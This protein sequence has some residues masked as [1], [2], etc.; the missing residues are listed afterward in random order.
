MSQ[1][2]SNHLLAA[3]S[4]SDRQRLSLFLEPV[5]LSFGQVLYEPDQTVSDAYFP[6]TAVISQLSVMEAGRGVETASI[7]NEGIIGVPLVLGTDRIPVRL[8]VQI[9]G[10]AL[11]ISATDLRSELS[12]NRSLQFLLLRYIQTLMNQIAQH[13]TCTQLHSS[14]DRCCCLLLLTHDRIGEP[15]LSLTQDLLSRMVGVRRDRVVEMVATLERFGLIEHQRGRLTIVNRAGLEAT[16][17]DCYA[18]LRSQ[19][20]QPWG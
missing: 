12:A 9:P 10:I 20:D 5:P 6:T 16:A 8:T 7:G 15:V 4:S 1:A 19:F 18:I 13:L 3:L 11:R 14:Q 2:Y 17:C